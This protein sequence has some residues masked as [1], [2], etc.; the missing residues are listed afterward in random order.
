[1]SKIN[2]G[3]KVRYKKKED[4]GSA[5]REWEGLEGIVLSSGG[6]STRVRV[7]KQSEYGEGI[8]GR[9]A[10]LTTFNLEVIEPKNTEAGVLNFGDSVGFWIESMPAWQGGRG[11]IRSYRGTGSG[12]LYSVEVTEVPPKNGVVRIGHTTE[13]YANQLR[14]SIDPEEIQVGDK[15]RVRYPSNTE[16]VG[17]V[18]MSKGEVTRTGVVAYIRK[19]ALAPRRFETAE[20]YLID[21]VGRGT[22]SYE[23]LERTPVKT[24]K[25]AKAGE[26]FKADVRYLGETLLTKIAENHWS[27]FYLKSGNSYFVND[28]AAQ[29]VFDSYDGAWVEVEDKR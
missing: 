24:C 23:L 12:A 5:Y 25:S 22:P 17:D 13:F 27:Q 14:R 2:V 11:I 6:S 15:I 8:V 9:E 20:G 1:M 19:M 18:E 7:T 28:E 16:T 4:I 26:Q 29:T 21:A 3:D 10:S